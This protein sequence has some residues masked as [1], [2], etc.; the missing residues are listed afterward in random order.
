MIKLKIT[1]KNL[2]IF[3]ELISVME[4]SISEKLDGHR[5]LTI[6]SLQLK[7]DV[8]ELNV[9]MNKL[10]ILVIKNTHTLPHKNIT[11]SI[12]PVQ[13]LIFIKYQSHLTCKTQ[14]LGKL[15]PFILGYSAEIHKQLTNLP[16]QIHDQNTRISY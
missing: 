13:S 2:M 8:H 4:K 9:F 11:I 1:K 10:M 3:I 12:T 14:I 7:V 16:M 15:T 6:D 5:K